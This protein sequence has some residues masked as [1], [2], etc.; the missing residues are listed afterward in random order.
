MAFAKSGIRLTALRCLLLGLVTSVTLAQDSD[1]EKQLEKVAAEVTKSSQPVKKYQLQYRLKQGELIRSRVVHLVS[2][3]TKIDGE[4]ENL[5]SRSVSTRVFE[6]NKVDSEGNIT[7]VHRVE[8]AELWQKVTGQDEVRYNS[9]T[10]EVVPER[11]ERIAASIGKPLAV[12]TVNASGAIVTRKDEVTQFNPGIGVLMPRLPDY[13][14]AIGQKWYTPEQVRIRLKDGRVQTVK[15]RKLYT[16]IRV[17]NELATIQVKT[18]VITPVHDAKVKSQLMQRMQHGQFQFDL[19]KG[20]IYSSQMELDE[21]VVGFNGAAS[22]IHY[23]SRM[24]EQLVSPAPSSKDLSV[25]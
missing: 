16:L 7:L 6:V 2:M 8:D 4:F 12:I 20:R 10:D 11:Y 23:L 14:I 3:D 13:P 24:T 19:A 17:A 25:R 15:L 18:Q 1:I 9:K 5:K 22:M 21:R